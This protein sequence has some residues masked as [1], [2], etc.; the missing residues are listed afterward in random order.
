M[1]KLRLHVRM[2]LRRLE[3]GGWR[4]EAGGWRLEVEAGGWRLEAGGWR[5]EE[6][7]RQ[8][9]RTGILVRSGAW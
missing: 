3:A 8:T 7:L 9:S 5:L 6:L 4:L 2:L 1:R